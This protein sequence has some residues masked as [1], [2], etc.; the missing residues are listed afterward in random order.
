MWGA[1]DRLMLTLGFRFSFYE[2]VL[3]MSAERRSLAYCFSALLLA[4]AAG[5]LFCLGLGG[6][7]IFDDRQNI[8]QNSA[9]M[10]A[11]GDLESL[12]YAAYSFSPG[13]GSRAL[14]MLSFAIDAWR[15][16]MDPVAFK[17]T[18]VLIHVVTTIVLMMFLRLL[19]VTAG[20]RLR[21]AGIGALLIAFIWAAHPMQVS[22]VLYVVQRMQMLATLFVVL[23]LWAY[24][25]ARR[26]QSIQKGG[27]GYFMLSFL[28]GVLG[29]ACKED[30]VLLPLYMLV[31]ELTVLRFSADSPR[32]ASV[33]RWSY[34][35]A[36]VLGL[37]IFLL[38]VMPKYWSWG[39]YPARE[40]SSYERLLTQCRVL[41]M[42]LGQM[43]FPLPSRLPFFYDDLEVSRGLLSP[44]STLLSGLSLVMLLALAW[45]WR[46]RL[47]VFAFGVLL[48]FAGHSL[49][50]N[51]LNLELAFEHR[52]HLPL[53]GVLLA[54]ADLTKWAVAR[55][56]VG[57]GVQICG[58]VLAFLIVSSFTAFRAYEWGE[59][60]RF[61]KAA[62]RDAP[63][64]ARA[65]LTLCTYYF[66]LS[67]GRPEMQHYVDQAI[68]TCEQGASRTNSALLP[69]NVII[70]K[71]IRGRAT[72]RDWRLFLDRLEVAP[73]N[74]ETLGVYAALVRNVE[75][76]FP[77]DPD[78]TIEALHVVLKHAGLTTSQYVELA[79]YV[80]NHSDEPDA[81]WPFLERAV[82]SA[83]PGDPLMKQ[84]LVDLERAGSPELVRRMQELQAQRAEAVAQK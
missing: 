60:G 2:W 42:Y 36:A 46:Q 16:G 72:A 80:F 31:L 37:M 8:A 14:S 75:L 20:W 30:A 23:S 47:P 22:S 73:V 83:E 57:N 71:T 55:F 3:Q 56:R 29:F 25:I 19:L 69:F 24:L 67:D 32:V 50:S 1:V 38:V 18:N 4:L 77:L 5:G 39:A 10:L 62:V 54:L 40:F 78:G 43:I 70:Y 58:L 65:W 11:G 26:K 49:T 12:L 33:L 17:I 74:A 48:F 52:N 81:A 51:I 53:L 41:V 34:A 15:G 68:T 63:H 82:R 6:G 35:I 21:R 28:A 45:W 27:R 61:A 64:S 76:G 7:F 44:P 59:G 79:V 84:V 9:L 66:D 13:K